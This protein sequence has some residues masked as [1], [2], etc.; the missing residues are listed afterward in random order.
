MHR[1]QR[2]FNPTKKQLAPFILAITALFALPS[3]ANQESDSDE[4]ILSELAIFSATAAVTCTD[5]TIIG[6]V[7]S[8]VSVTKTNCYH[9]GDVA[10]PVPE[11]VLSDFSDQYSRLADLTCDRMLTTL[12]GQTLKPGTY[13]F[14]QASTNTGGVLTLERN[15]A[16]IKEGWVFKVAVGALTGTDFVVKMSGEDANAC[17]VDWWVAEAAT[18]TR[19]DFIGNIYAGGAITLTGAA[20][21]SPFRGRALS[22]AAV[23]IT[24]SNFDGCVAEQEIDVVKEPAEFCPTVAATDVD[25]VKYTVAGG[26]P[27]IAVM[28]PDS[29]RWYKYEYELYEGQEYWYFVGPPITETTR[30]ETSVYATYE[31]WDEGDVREFHIDLTKNVVNECEFYNYD[32]QRI[33]DCVQRPIVESGSSSSLTHALGQWL[34]VEE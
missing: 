12:A 21:T 22:N 30:N 14:D 26:D 27:Q 11:Q 23:T 13:C 34:N 19:G 24:N 29:K 4:P 16:D 31:V 15:S 8:P 9:A 28:A 2:F 10:I 32:N 17:N 25:Y 1:Y 18:I 7:A 20:P 5:S 33:A 3:H 6:D